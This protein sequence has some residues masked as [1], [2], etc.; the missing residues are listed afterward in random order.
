MAAIQNSN[1]MVFSK[2]FLSLLT[3]KTRQDLFKKKEEASC[4]LTIDDSKDEEYSAYKKDGKPKP[5]AAEAIRSY[6]DFKAICDYFLNKKQYEYYALWVVG[7]CLGIRMSDLRKL[8]FKH[9]FTDTWKFRERTVIREKKTEKINNML[10]TEA[11]KEA[12]MMYIENDTKLVL[13]FNSYVFSSPKDT[14]KPI[15][16]SGW[17]KVLSAAADKTGVSENVHISTHTM[18]KTFSNIVLC[19]DNTKI[20]MNSI[21][22]IQGLLNHSN[23]TTTFR[24]LGAMK[25]LYDECRK[26]VSDFCMGKTKQK[27]LTLTI[28]N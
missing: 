6:D 7:V 3:E 9:F 2:E 23:Q 14:S 24:Y 11:V 15:T 22:K 18:R 26:T 16:L 28:I 4:D 12:L 25:E 21:T 20:D 1:E 27:L 10:I 19:C 8:K 13:N 5:T 17:Y